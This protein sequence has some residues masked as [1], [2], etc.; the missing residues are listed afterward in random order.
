LREVRAARLIA[1]IAAASL[2]AAAGCGQPGADLFVVSRTGAG[3]GAAV[4]LRVSD[5]GFVRCNGGRRLRITDPQLLLAREIERELDGDAKQRRSL[6]P[7]PQSVFSYRVRL[8]SGVV[9]FSDTS[10]GIGKEERRLAAFTREVATG[11]C[12][13]AR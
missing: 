5:D 9:S 6:P 12:H 4:T 11:P 2:A 3:A 8:E 10:P 13:L 1:G 7:G